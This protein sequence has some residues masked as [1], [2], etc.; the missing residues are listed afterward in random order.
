MEHSFLTKVFCIAASF[1]LIASVQA[2]NDPPTH[3]SSA[4][5]IDTG[6]QYFNDGQYADALDAWN[7][8]L[9]EY[10]LKNDKR[11]QA[12]VLMYKANAYLSIWGRATR[13]LTL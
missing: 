6:Q 11:G 13:Q 8:A 9:E 3:D 12:R 1:L 5:L 4:G 7:S 10:R 2:A